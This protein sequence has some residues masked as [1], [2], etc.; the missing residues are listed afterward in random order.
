MAFDPAL[1]LGAAMWL[2]SGIGLAAL[3][4]GNRTAAPLLAS[5]LLASALCWAG[6]PFNFFFWLVIDVAVILV[7]ARPEMTRADIWIVLLFAPAWALYLMPESPW[8]WWG[9]GAVVIA[10]FMLTVPYARLAAAVKARWRRRRAPRRRD[11]LCE[12]G[13][14]A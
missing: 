2:A 7:I 11:L 1:L 12:A 5:F 3:V 10:Q 8:M 9:T 6:V 14:V 13:C 4:A